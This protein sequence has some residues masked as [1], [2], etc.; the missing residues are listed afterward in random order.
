M[1]A[2]THTNVWI[3]SD[4]LVYTFTTQG[5]AY[6]VGVFYKISKPMDSAFYHTLDYKA[7][8]VALV[9]TEY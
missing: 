5:T 7:Q 4:I 2:D 9:H 3:N 1:P 8:C 6:K